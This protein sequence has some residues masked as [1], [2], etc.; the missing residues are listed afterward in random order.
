MEGHALSLGQFWAFLLNG[1]PQTIEL[2]VVFGGN[3]DL[4]LWEQLI[5][6]HFL[7]IPPDTQSPSSGEVRL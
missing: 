2:L 7:D 1:F 4:V 6:N 5:I 3:D